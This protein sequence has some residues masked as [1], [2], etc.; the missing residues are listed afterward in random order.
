MPRSSMPLCHRANFLG[1]AC[2][3]SSKQVTGPSVKKKP[4]MPAYNATQCHHSQS[5]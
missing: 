2:L 4:N 3:A 5:Q 1:S